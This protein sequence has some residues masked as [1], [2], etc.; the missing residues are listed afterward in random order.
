MT[1]PVSVSTL[2]PLHI[3]A[4][5]IRKLTPAESR[6]FAAQLENMLNQ[7]YTTPTNYD[8]YA[9][10]QTYATVEKNGKVIATLLNNG[11]MMTSNAIGFSLGHIP[12]TGSG[13]ALAQARAEAIA[14]QLGGSIHKASTALTQSQYSSLPGL[15]FR[16]DDA[17]MKA[18][19]MYA[20][21]QA[22]LAQQEDTQTD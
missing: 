7:Q 9:G 21:L 20:T 17:A 3:P 12:D 2:T 4:S 11:G 15:T 1:T 6:E 8:T 10:N 13:P 16:R 14:K 22:L 5:A 19:P 18:D